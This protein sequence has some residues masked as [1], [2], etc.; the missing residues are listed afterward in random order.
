M[1]S[2]HAA[3]LRANLYN[4]SCHNEQIW[5]LSW[6]CKVNIYFN[7]IL[8]ILR[9]L[10][11]LVLTTAAYQLITIELQLCEWVES[12]HLDIFI[13]HIR[14]SCRYFTFVYMLIIFWQD[15]PCENTSGTSCPRTIHYC[16]S[17]NYSS[18]TSTI[19]NY[20]ESS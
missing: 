19:C 8:R 13:I 4:V 1:S 10:L 17:I 3:K 14:H 12:G 16:Q 2:I 5:H 20:S 15:N 11:F 7:I 18:H 6:C 9:W